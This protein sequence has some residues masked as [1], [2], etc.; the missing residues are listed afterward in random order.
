MARSRSVRVDNDSVIVEVEDDRPRSP[1]RGPP[2]LRLVLYHQRLRG[3]G[4]D[5]RPRHLLRHRGA[6][7]RRRDRRHRTG[8][9][10]VSRCDPCC[11]TAGIVCRRW[12]QLVN[13]LS[14]FGPTPNRTGVWPLPGAGRHLGASSVLRDLRSQGLLRP[15]EESTRPAHAVQPATRWPDPK[16]Q[17]K[18]GFGATSTRPGSPSTEPRPGPEPLLAPY[19][20]HSG[21]VAQPVR[22]ADS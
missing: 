22:A 7:P 3:K 9:N 14:R 21:P 20:R 15:V 16:S 11:R 12:T 18:C 1:G 5:S 2:R 8:A 4:P 13:T 19:N 10:D 17:P 6:P